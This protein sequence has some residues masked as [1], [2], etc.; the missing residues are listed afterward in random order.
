[1]L[2][3]RWYYYWPFP[4]HHELKY[5]LLGHHPP[6]SQPF[7]LICFSFF[8]KL[9]L[10]SEL[11]LWSQKSDCLGSHTASLP[12]D[13]LALDGTVYSVSLPI[14]FFSHRMG[15]IIDPNSL[16]LGTLLRTRGALGLSVLRALI[17]RATAAHL[18]HWAV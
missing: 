5:L 17:S 2:L 16:L 8:M 6:Y 3:P 9:F 15:L 1:M 18:V 11:R 7:H 14:S 4:I 10:L 13:S 12:T